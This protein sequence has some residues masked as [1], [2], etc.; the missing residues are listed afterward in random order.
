[1]IKALW[2]RLFRMHSERS[3]RRLADELEDIAEH[4]ANLKVLDD[5]PAD[6]ILGYVE[7]GLPR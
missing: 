6:E 2:D 7:C 1:M 5:R 3:R 4:C